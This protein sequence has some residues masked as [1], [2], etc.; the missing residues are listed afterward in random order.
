MDF[1]ELAKKRYSVRSYSDK[2]VEKEILD[3]IL[4]AG[5]IAPTAK[6]QQP[7][8]IYVIEDAALLAKLDTLPPCRYNAPTALIFTY[9][10]DEDWKNPNEEGIHAGI[11]DVSIVATHI[12]LQA[13]EL[14]LGTTWCNMFGNTALEKAF[15]LPANE[16]SVLFMDLGYTAA[17]A[18]PSPRHSEKKPLEATVK[19]L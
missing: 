2:K 4:E 14:G 17:D 9:N 15:D 6:N 5:N 7:Q 13:A 1:I 19:Y 16:R 8:R 10:T 3:K 11:E 18:E 12:M